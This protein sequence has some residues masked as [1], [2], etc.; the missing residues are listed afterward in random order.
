MDPSDLT[1]PVGDF[2]ASLDREALFKRTMQRA[3]VLGLVRRRRRRVLQLVP[4]LALVLVLVATS[5]AVLVS[6]SD[7]RG[8]G[9]AIGSSTST[10][11]TTTAPSVAPSLTPK[12]WVPVDFGDLQ[13]SVPASWKLVDPQVCSFGARDTVYVNQVKEAPCLGDASDG[14]FPPDNGPSVALSVLRAMPS[15]EV[16]PAD[17]IT[18]NGIHVLKV[19]LLEYLALG[20]GIHLVGRGTAAI[21]RTLTY[22][23]RDVALGA[24]KAPTVPESWRWMNEPGWRVAV[25][26]VW[27]ADGHDIGPLDYEAPGC[28]PGVVV[29]ATGQPAAVVD[30]DR[31]GFAFCPP[32]ALPLTR[33]QKPI[34]GVIIDV[35]PRVGGWPGGTE[36]C[37]V[38][39][40]LRACVV[41]GRPDIDILF[42]WV[43]AADQPSPML[44]EIGLAGTGVTART[45]LGSLQATPLLAR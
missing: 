42:V 12:G 22:S 5:V 45:I 32:P 25:P 21:L 44:L 3:A 18:I 37:H 23:P 41:G 6:R 8:S 17:L 26:S 15:V 39:N 38:S 31:S 7:H 40:G 9:V 24:G 1:P 27:L 19:G 13:I 29:L 10:T 14:V 28:T 11:T 33:V 16:V 35:K 36:A 43:H 4:A 30:L 34:G 20:I 2:V